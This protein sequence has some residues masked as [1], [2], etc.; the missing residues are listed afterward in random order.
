M[1]GTWL[2]SDIA[3][4]PTASPSL[5]MLSDSIPLGVGQGERGLQHPVTG[6][7][8]PGLVLPVGAR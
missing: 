1:L 7:R 4:T 6:Q 2:Y 5:R 8:G 3:S